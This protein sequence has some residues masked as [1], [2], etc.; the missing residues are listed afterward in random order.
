M[1][2]KWTH[3]LPDV[4]RL[5]TFWLPRRGNHGFFK[6]LLRFFATQESK[7]K[8]ERRS[9]KKNAKARAASVKARP[10]QASS[11]YNHTGAIGARAKD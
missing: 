1:R 10:F 8:M 2:D 7:E 9:W 3:C 6:Q 5:A 4:A 11:H